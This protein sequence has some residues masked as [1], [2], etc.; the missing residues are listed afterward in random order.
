MRFRDPRVLGIALAA[1]ALAAPAGAGA[2]TTIGSPLTSAAQ[3]ASCGPS[4]FTNTAVGIGTLQAPY[5]GVI[6]RWRMKLQTGGGS[7]TYKL[8]VIRPA[9]GSNYTGAG[10]GPAQTA[11]AAGVNV[12]ELPTPLPVKAGDLIAVDCP[13]GAPAAMATSPP[14]ASKLAFFNPF[15]TDGSTKSP[16]NQLGGEEEMINADVVGVPNITSVGPVSGSTLGGTTVTIS[17]SKLADVTGVTFGG[18]AATAFTVINDNQVTA[19][20]P[21]HA[22]GAA[23]VQAS[24]AA[25]SSAAAAFT[26]VAPPPGAPTISNLSQ[27]HGT[28]KQRRGTTFAFT[29]NEQA[30]VSLAFGQ[31]V[32][33]RRVHGRCVA[34][35]KRNHTRPAC[36]RT[37]KRGTLTFSG[38]SGAN[39]LSFKGRISRSKR[40]QPGRYAVTI[41][42]TSAGGQK[43]AKQTLS[44][45]ILK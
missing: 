33:G 31:T 27:S 30:S 21:A 2:S 35:T 14:A 45:T 26:Y 37:V 36:K 42:A 38:K 10:T 6:V 28:W 34:P 5:D 4:T 17:G 12:I 43:S 16:N 41:V 11:P 7:F 15:L 29:L 3:V 32:P 8:R 18:M 40:L 24:S 13:N 39:K 22:A 1:A 19:T 9:G 23:N 25:G 44:F 20:A